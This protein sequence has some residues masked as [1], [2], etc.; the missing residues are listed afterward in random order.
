ME[1]ILINPRR[2]RGRRRK[3]ART[4]RRARSHRR[5]R[6]HALANPHRR[7]RGS[8]R[9]SRVSSRRS[10]RVGRNPRI[11]FIGGVNIGQLAAGGLGYVG[12]R[13]A[14]GAVLG[15][16]PPQWSADPNTAPLVRIGVKAVVGLGVLPLIAGFIP[17]MKNMKGAIRTG[18]GIAV[19]VD[20]FETY[21]ARFIPLPMSDYEQ[22]AITGYEPGM[23]TGVGEGLIEP[24]VDT[25]AY[26]GSAY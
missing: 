6:V 21:V 10:R 20:L 19:V 9:R 15:F 1:G 8:H 16:L 12:T 13:Y 2:R 4:H 11:P 26:G 17:G 24:A 7:R 3:K 23:I 18:A 14:T 25:D 5:R 22:G